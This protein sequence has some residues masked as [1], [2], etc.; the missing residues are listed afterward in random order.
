VNENNQDVPMN[1]A[2]AIPE[3]RGT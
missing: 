2:G 3:L 1:T